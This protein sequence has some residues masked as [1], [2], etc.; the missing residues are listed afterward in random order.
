LHA[1]AAAREVDDDTVIGAGVLL[2]DRD[3]VVTSVS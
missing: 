3:D 1:I 2:C